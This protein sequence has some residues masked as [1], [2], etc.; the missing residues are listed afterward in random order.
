MRL[1]LRLAVPAAALLLAALPVALPAEGPPAGRPPKEYFR[2]KVASLEGRRIQI[3]YDFSDPAQ[4]G[5]W[6]ATYPFVK[7]AANGGWRVDQGALRGDGYAGWRHR[8]VFDGEVKIAA[9]LSSED[10]KNFGAMVLDEDR[11]VFDIFALADLHF[12]LMDGKQ[13]LMHMVATFQPPGQ[14]PNGST[15]WR[16]VQTG[17]EP[18]ISSQAV[19]IQVRK[20][21]GQNE[22]R[23]AGTGKLAG[24]DKE[25]RIGPRLVPGFY[26]LG[27]RVVVAKAAV[28]GVLDAKW[29]KENGISFEDRVPSDPD[30]LPP[31]KGLGD[32]A[33][34]K[35]PAA[36]PADPNAGAWM[37]MVRKMANPAGARAD[38][39]KAADDLVASKEKRAMRVLIDM[40]YNE[41]D[42]LGREVACKAFKGLSGK[43]P[44]YNP[45]APREARIKSMQRVWDCWYQVKDV[46][47]REDAKKKGN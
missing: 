39:E 37:D 42:P 22:F 24:E 3:E 18:R 5:D 25:T 27:A 46:L 16:Y 30:S 7:P 12:A 9:T 19:D 40:M 14:G 47:D 44:G 28:S 43:D 36:P 29:L 1:R 17:W 8:A 2:G 33:A 13:P 34:E 32:K 26:T 10:A 11:P 21:G 6:C 31:E 4:S 45:A 35:D 23:F 15:E 20:R 41:D 38:R